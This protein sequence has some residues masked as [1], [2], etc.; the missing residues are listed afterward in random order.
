MHQNTAHKPLENLDI[1]SGQDYL[2]KDDLVT[3]I[4]II[5]CGAAG[6]ATLASLVECIKRSH[7]QQ[8]KINIFEK[9]PN[10]GP[11]LAYQFDSDDLLMN[12]VSS[13]TS[14]NVN[15]E[16][17]FW[18]WVIQRGHAIG[19][20]HIMSR[21]GISPDGYV[22]RQFF[23]LYL[24]DRFND[25]I[26]E[27]KKINIPVKLVNQEVIDIQHSNT[28][29]EVFDY[30]QQATQFDYVILCLGNTDPQDIFKLD[31]KRQYVNNPYP[32]NRYA[33]GIKKDDCVGII[34]GQ[35]T[36]ADIAVVL[37][38]QGHTGPIHFFTRGSNYPLV[39]CAKENYELKHFNLL[40]LE[41]I[42]ARNIGGISLRQAFRLAR[43][44]F[45]RI[46][47][48]WKTFL[49]SAE[50]PYKDWIEHLFSKGH[51]Y[52]NWQHFAIASD[53]VIGD[54]WNALSLSSKKIFMDKYHRLWMCKRVPLPI[55]TYLKIYSL[56][57]SGILK[58]HTQ[59]LGIEVRSSDKFTALLAGENNSPNHVHVHCDWIINATGPARSVDVNTKSLLIRN[60]IKSR[61]ISANPFGGI[62]LDYET[63]TV[64]NNGKRI[65]NF[66]AVG[67][68]TSGT[69]FFVSSLD[70][71]AL[72][73]MRVARALVDS[74][75]RS[76]EPRKTIERDILG[77]ENAI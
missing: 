62:E 65:D 14:I 16:T 35:L 39:R 4:A 25:S 17:D 37:A 31:G 27:A 74:S 59:L 1:F 34:G 46:G 70:M 53:A 49:I 8:Y 15:R 57:K 29:F 52:E 61:L 54:Y 26:S 13:T 58:H 22:S 6:V 42:R 30:S 28:C 11:G 19:T 44:E 10:F 47:I 50:L 77:V 71:V 18:E 66:Y 3:S 38:R 73:A 48:E 7:H 69:H 63:S 64:K 2:N 12:M 36:A 9:S 51:I 23:G 56:F 76:I 75:S 24:K 60:L 33:M 43:K 67:H 45:I 72:G 68:L 55:H 20:D 21:S 41:V 32:I 40:N 5:G